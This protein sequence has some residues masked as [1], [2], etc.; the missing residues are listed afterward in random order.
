MVILDDFIAANS[1]KIIAR[2]R[3]KATG[4]SE[5][6]PVPEMIERGVPVLLEQLVG[7][8]RLGREPG[9]EIS[10]HRAAARARFSSRRVLR[11]RGR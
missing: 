10:E 5:S 4:R 9:P 2:C 3:E 1:D 7:V 11:R 8:L 6:P